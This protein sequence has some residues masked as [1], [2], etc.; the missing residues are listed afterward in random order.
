[1]RK[2]GVG[3]VH[4]LQAFSIAAGIL[5]VPAMFFFCRELGMRFT[6]SLSAALLLAFAPNVW[7]YGGTAFSDLPSIVIVIVAVAFLLRGRSD[8]RAYLAS[9]AIL[10]CA[11]SMR[12]QNLLICAAPSLLASWF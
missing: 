1:V 7:F 5:I 3:D 10:V 8:A 12:P 4:A 11:A 2:F 9:A 6:T